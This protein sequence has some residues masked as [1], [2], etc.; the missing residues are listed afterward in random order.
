MGVTRGF[1]TFFPLMPFVSTRQGLSTVTR[2]PR[3]SLRV[4]NDNDSGQDCQ[5][6]QGEFPIPSDELIKLAQEI[7]L[8]KAVGI[9]DGG[10]CLGD[11]FVF[12]VSV[13]EKDK[14]EYLKALTSVFNMESAFT[15]SQNCFGWTVD[16]VQHNRV[17]V[18]C[19]Q[20]AV[21]DKQEFLGVQPSGKRLIFPPQCYYM[22]FNIQGQLVEFGANAVD[23]FQ[24]N[25]GGL[26]G[27]FGYLYGI[28]KRMPFPEGQPPKLSRR[29]RFFDAIAGFLDKRFA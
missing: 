19:R 20:S 8:E 2:T 29:L 28:G 3:S 13:M 16:P 24:G 6:H 1:E 27:A 10:A 23:I 17:W 5:D 25:T 15:I 14:K 26:I 21:H 12:R 4:L 22:D 18:L 7:L 9:K 11:E